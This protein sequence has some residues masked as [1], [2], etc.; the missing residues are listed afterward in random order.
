LWVLAGGLA[1]G[2]AGPK[3]ARPAD[4]ASKPVPAPPAWSD[5]PTGQASSLSD[6]GK[7]IIK[8]KNIQYPNPLR[9]GGF[10]EVDTTT[11]PPTTKVNTELAWVT[12]VQKD[13]GGATWTFR[14]HPRVVSRAIRVPYHGS[15]GSQTVVEHVLIGYEVSD[16]ER[17]N[18][19]INLSANPPVDHRWKDLASAFPSISS[20]ESDTEGL[21]WLVMYGSNPFWDS[22][23]NH[24]PYDVVGTPGGNKPNVA[25][26]ADWDKKIQLS[27]N[28]SPM[29]WAFRDRPMKVENAIRIPYR[30]YSAGEWYRAWLLVGY[31]GGGAF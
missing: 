19:K 14:G 25:Q 9:L 16:D 30:A 1:V 23:N 17:P 31:E 7:K 22:S 10:V 20:W 4:A 15:D 2:A 21:G 24:A 26:V 3:G 13:L 29:W 11:T 18:P 12:Y 6:L 8:E 28:K 5:N 27:S